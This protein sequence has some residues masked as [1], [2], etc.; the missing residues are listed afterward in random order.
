MLTGQPLYRQSPLLSNYEYKFF[1][2]KFR[3]KERDHNRNHKY[4]KTS[5]CSE[6]WTL[7]CPVVSEG[8]SFISSPNTKSLLCGLVYLM[9]EVW[10]VTTLHSVTTYTQ[11]HLWTRSV[12]F[13]RKWNGRMFSQWKQTTKIFISEIK[14]G[15][16]GLSPTSSSNN[17]VCG[18]QNKTFPEIKW[19][20][21]R[22]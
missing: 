13:L 5:I 10:S 3:R 20:T 21:S 2:K 6:A 22:E 8:M 11:D 4:P 15:V 7:F 18:L 19:D 16:R 14:V 9:I 12:R 1:K 17:Y